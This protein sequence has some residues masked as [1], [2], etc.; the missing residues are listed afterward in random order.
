MM[1]IV[2]PLL[3]CELGFVP[4]QRCYAISADIAQI[5]LKDS[6]RH[7]ADGHLVAVQEDCRLIDSG[8]LRN[9]LL[10]AGCLTPKSSLCIEHG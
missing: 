3:A 8:I 5:A 10:W 4:T 1:L 2:V 7:E 6:Y 9:E